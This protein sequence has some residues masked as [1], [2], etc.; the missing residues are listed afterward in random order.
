MD[1]NKTG[2]PSSDLCAGLMETFPSNQSRI[3]SPFAEL[4]GESYYFRTR[5]SIRDDFLCQ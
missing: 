1:E 5:E 4:N 2:K 3:G